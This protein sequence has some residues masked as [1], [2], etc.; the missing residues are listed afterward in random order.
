MCKHKYPEFYF[1]TGKYTLT[2][3]YMNAFLLKIYMGDEKH[4]YSMMK[5]VTKLPIIRQA[6]KRFDINTIKSKSL[7]WLMFWAAER[8]I[9]H[10]KL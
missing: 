3:I 5:K 6:F 9:Y 4:K 2:N 8:K 1:D 7:D 10:S